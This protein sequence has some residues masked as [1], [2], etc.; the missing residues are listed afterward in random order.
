MK[1]TS[2]LIV[3][4]LVLV[5]A[6]AATPP[7]GAQSTF[8]GKTVTVIVGYAPSGGYDLITRMVARHLPRFCRGRPRSSFK[9]CRA[10]EA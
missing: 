1:A 9:T 10:R 5:L 6:G 3:G 8:A 7:A 4:G 2:A